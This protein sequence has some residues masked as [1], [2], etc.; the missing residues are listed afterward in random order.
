MRALKNLSWDEG[1]AVGSKTA[2]KLIEYLDEFKP[3][4]ILDIGSGLT[5]VLFAEWSKNNDAEVISLEHQEKYYNATK[6]LLDEYGLEADLRLC[7]LVKTKWGMFYETNI[8]K[9]L[10][11]VLID[12]PPGSIGR[13]ATLYNIYPN[14]SKDFTAWLDDC[15]RYEEQRILKQWIRD[16][17]VKVL[18]IEG[19]SRGK[20]IK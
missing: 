1:W 19:L 13:G 11:F 5:T 2:Y 15:N 9:D 8:P 16:L 18:D 3:K 10:D 14:L 12:G 4:K 20:I 7:E 17:D 6:K